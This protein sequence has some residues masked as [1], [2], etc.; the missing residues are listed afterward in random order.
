MTATDTLDRPALAGGLRDRVRQIVAQ[1]LAPQVDAIDRDGIYPEAFMR[2]LGAEGVYQSHLTASGDGVDLYEAIDVMSVVARECLT[3]G[4][5]NWCQDALGWYVENTAN[6]GLRAKLLG[7]VARGVVLG[8]TGLSNPMKTFAGIETLRLRGRRLSDGWEV[9]GLLPWVSNLGADHLF[10]AIFENAD[11]PGHRVMALVDCAADGVTLA[12]NA[13]FTALEGSR[14]F[15]VRFRRHFI[16]DAMV[17]SDPAMDMVR[18]IKPGFVLL[19]TGMA[20]GLIE[21]CVDIMNDAWSALSHV[22]CYLDDQPGFFADQVA[23]ARETTKALCA[24]PFNDDPAYMKAI[25]ELRLAGGELSLRAAQAAM[26]HA[27]ASGYLIDA[28]AQRRL[29]EAQFIAIVTPATK[30]LRKEIAEMSRH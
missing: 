11:D 25:L 30:H 17:L 24:E 12:Q 27:G 2:R 26:L 18:R 7:D 8:G 15:A 4:F 29:R 14:T 5:C 6:D 9:S 19:Q 3:T 22:N 10:G 23:A 16:P 20:F 13:H 1:D 28:A 21:A